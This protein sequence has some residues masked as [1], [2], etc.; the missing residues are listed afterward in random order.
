MNKTLKQYLDQNFN[1][2][3]ICTFIQLP[4]C[5]EDDAHTIITSWKSVPRYKIE[6]FY[7]AELIYA[8][9]GFNDYEEAQNQII[10]KIEQYLDRH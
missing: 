3:I 5:F 6:I 10:K 8:K 7:G 1:F 4:R 9:S 2:S